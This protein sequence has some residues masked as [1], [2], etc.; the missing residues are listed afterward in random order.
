MRNDRQRQRAFEQDVVEKA[1][2]VVHMCDGM[3]DAG[4]AEWDEAWEALC[5]AVETLE[6]EEGRT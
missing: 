1:K 4:D 6:V 3:I 2:T 5:G